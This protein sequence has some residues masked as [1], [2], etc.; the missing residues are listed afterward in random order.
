MIPGFE[1]INLTKYED[2]GISEMEELPADGPIRMEKII[3]QKWNTIDIP[4]TN[5]QWIKS[6]T[7]NHPDWKYMYWTDESSRK[8]IF[9]KY[10]YLLPV[11]DNY[12]ENMR[13]AD[14]MRYVILYEFGGVYADLDMESRLPLDAITRKYSCILAQE[15]Y[16]HPLMDTGF[17]H[18]VTN[19]FMACKAGHPFMKQLIENLPRFAKMFH[20]LDS[21]GPHYINLIYNDYMQNIKFNSS[22]V[23]HVQLVPA[24]YF[25]PTIDP[26]KH[27]DMK[28][29][30]LARFDS[31]P[32][33]RQ[34]ACLSLK[35][36]GVTR[37]PYSYS[38]AVHHW[39]HT[40]GPDF[41]HTR[42]ISIFDIVPHAQI[43]TSS[44]FAQTD[45]S[46]LKT[47]THHQQ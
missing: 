11:Y 5:L 16:E 21:T 20:L 42:N 15:P 30:C 19:A 4:S 33:I 31:M 39:Q 12:V 23:N 13:R 10:S 26:L 47:N 35:L 7:K 32:F 9:D 18:L 45:H 36:R 43:Y 17:E 27:D 41:S 46:V 44:T 2:L 37:K 34:R 22:G 28:K 38:F 3:H 1:K 6:W 40:Y 14:A 24:E 8:L 25:F 29:L